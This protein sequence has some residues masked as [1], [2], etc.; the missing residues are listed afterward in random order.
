MMPREKR[1]NVMKLPALAI[2]IALFVFGTAKA[3]AAECARELAVSRNVPQLP[4]PSACRAM[5][6]LHLDMSYAQML[7]AIGPPDATAVPAIGY[8]DVV[9]VFPA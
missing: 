2:L 5:G 3:T 1:E 6:P 7:A 4:L 9:Y 8:R